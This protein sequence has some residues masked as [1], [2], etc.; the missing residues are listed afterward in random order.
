MNEKF[1]QHVNALHPKFEELMAS[2]PSHHQGLPPN[3]PPRGV[4]LFSDGSDHLYVGRSNALRKRY[5]MHTRP[6]ADSN[7]APFAFKLARKATGRTIVSY[8]PG[9]GT[10]K[11]LSQEPTF[12]AAFY[13]AKLRIQKMDF[14]FVQEDDPTRQALLE[15]YCAIALSAPFN[16][17]DNH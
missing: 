4:Y 13:E 5:G 7:T 11:W 8:R 9:D 14:R 12:K 1:A 3:M 16:D 2:S 10:R 6:S 17:F 15:M